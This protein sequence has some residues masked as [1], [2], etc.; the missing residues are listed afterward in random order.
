MKNNISGK[1]NISRKEFLNTILWLIALP[2]ILLIGMS[3]KRHRNLQNN[4]IVAVSKNIN[5]G[6]TFHDKFIIVKKKD[7]IRFLSSKCTHLG[8]KITSFE[9]NEFICP[10]HGSTFTIEGKSTKGPAAIPLKELAFSIDKESGE[11]IIN[12]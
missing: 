5:E 12:M 7:D 4:S 3:V 10:C 9:N 6:V 1:R 11:Y 8:C 2:F